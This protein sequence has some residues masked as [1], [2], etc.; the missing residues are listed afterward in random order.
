MPMPDF[1]F[2]KCE[3]ED[4]SFN[5][6]HDSIFASCDDDGYT[7]FW[8]MRGSTKPIFSMQNH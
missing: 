1:T 2:H 3:I 7:A 4:V 6:F 8:D 5:H